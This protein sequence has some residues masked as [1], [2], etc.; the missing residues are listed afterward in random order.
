MLLCALDG[1]ATKT[2]CVLF[3]LCRFEV[4]GVGVSGG[5]NFKN[6]GAEVAKQNVYQAMSEALRMAGSD[7]KSVD[8]LLFGL[9]GA[10]DSEGAT[11]NI[12]LKQIVGERS[13]T[14]TNDGVQAYK[15][16]NLN[17]EGCVFAAGTGSVG[18]Y[19]AN[20]ELKRI[21]GWGWFCGDEGSAFWI[22]RSALNKAVRCFDGLEKP[23][24]IV[25][26]VEEYFGLSFK[27]AI[28]KVHREHPVELVAGFARVVSRL[29][30]SGDEVAK[31]V[32]QSAALEISSALVF[33][34]KILGGHAKKSVVGGVALSKIVRQ[35]ISERLPDVSYYYG[36]LVALG[37]ILS[38]LEECGV[39]PSYELRDELIK[40]LNSK[41][42]LISP[43]KLSRYLS[44]DKVESV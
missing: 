40:M 16:A 18:Y 43:Q 22:A 41:L 2:L 38:L 28:A 10:G 14:L 6:V 39:N 35:E 13:F 30:E 26:A 9:A 4:I 29:A 1:G 34:E 31:V 23:T 7:L 37:G 33:M 11:L 15:L 17:D 24:K 12:F 27:E 32:M 44:I 36:H 42:K 3:D 25:H 5:S 8:K 19:K 20:G 21:G